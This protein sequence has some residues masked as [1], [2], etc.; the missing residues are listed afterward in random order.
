M[1]E[2]LHG[3]TFPLHVMG[4]SLLLNL[5]PVMVPWQPSLHPGISQ[6]QQWNLPLWWELSLNTGSTVPSYVSAIILPLESWLLQ[7]RK[8]E[9]DKL[10]Y[11]PKKRKR[12]RN[13]FW[14]WLLKYITFY[15]KSCDIFLIVISELD[16]S[17]PDY[18]QFFFF[19]YYFASQ[20]QNQ[21]QRLHF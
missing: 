10:E 16:S 12:I 2:N 1:P 20:N 5:F 19:L 8:I 21:K 14:L 7:W 18:K 3:A 4:Q 6:A 11:Q 17:I 15:I 13:S 9:S